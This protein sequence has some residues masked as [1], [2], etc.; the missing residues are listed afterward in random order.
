M[1]VV[2]RAARL[3]AVSALVSD[4]RVSVAEADPADDWSRLTASLV[5]ALVDALDAN[6][7]EDDWA[8]WARSLERW[9]RYPD[10]DVRQLSAAR[11]CVWCAQQALHARSLD[12]AVGALRGWPVAG[13]PEVSPPES[14][15]TTLPPRAPA[16]VRSTI[17]WF[18][19]Q[20]AD[21]AMG[22]ERLLPPR[23]A[24]VP[25]A[26]L[27][28]SPG[29]GVH[30]YL[31]VLV[32]E[33][34]DRGGWFVARHPEDAFVP[35]PAAD[36][37]QAL[38]DAFAAACCLVE[39]DAQ[40]PRGARW[41]LLDRRTSTPLGA[42][43]GR[44]ASGAAAFAFWHALHHPVKVPDALLVLAQVSEQS[45]HTALMPVEHVD[46]KTGAIVVEHHAG[47]PGS[48]ADIIDTIVVVTE[49]DGHAVGNVL[50]RAFGAAAPVRVVSL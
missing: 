30:G 4:A 5:R 18:D 31:A 7:G 15:G 44:S 28:E 9:G 11:W 3:Q 47:A 35:E 49:E 41:R 32:V 33:V 21:P 20:R 26:L 27:R 23:S 22:S 29:G 8:R 40:R 24:R 6:P 2:D 39:P 38:D 19:E 13:A 1:T 48:A 36:F 12:G 14:F 34:V 42:P 46:E 25:V 37:C 50:R 45:N 43:A 10:I 16:W 17:A